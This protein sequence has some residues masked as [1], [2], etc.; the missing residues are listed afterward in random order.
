MTT[1]AYIQIADF[2]AKR[3]SIASA[4]AILGTA[5][6]FA[7]AQFSDMTIADITFVAFTFCNSLRVLAYIPQ[8]TKAITDQSGAEAIS[9]WT[10]GL[11]LASNVTAIAYAVENKQDWLM[12]FLFLGNALGCVAIL[13][14]A[15]WKR[16][17]HR[18]RIEGL[19]TI[20]ERRHRVDG[21]G[22]GS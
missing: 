9:F 11:F 16:S 22:S 5:T 3:V 20:H 1:L 8:I 12:A 19:S 2:S 21:C 14:I 13:M 15:A 4:V 17:L 6:A 7:V 18:R 10:W